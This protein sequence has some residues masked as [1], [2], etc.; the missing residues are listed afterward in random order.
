MAR[1]Q[2]FPGAQFLIEDR[3]RVVQALLWPAAHATARSLAEQL[4]LPLEAADEGPAELRLLGQIGQRLREALE[5]MEL[6]GSATALA[7]RLEPVAVRGGAGEQAVPVQVVLA[8]HAT[9]LLGEQAR[10]SALLADGYLRIWLA[11]LGAVP[12]AAKIHV[13]ALRPDGEVLATSAEVTHAPMQLELPWSSPRPPG[14]IA[15]AVVL[16]DG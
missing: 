15:V 11:G 10:G 13:A 8:E 1:E 12:T 7:A 2:P 9:P 6:G 14:E 3:D 4:G 5:G 16:T